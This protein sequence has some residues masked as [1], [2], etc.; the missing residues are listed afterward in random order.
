MTT[1]K[2]KMMLVCLLVPNGFFAN[3]WAP[4]SMNVGM[5]TALSV[6]INM[7]TDVR[8]NLSDVQFFVRIS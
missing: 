6:G 7:I 8:P 1:V 2:K 5:Y 4:V 3:R